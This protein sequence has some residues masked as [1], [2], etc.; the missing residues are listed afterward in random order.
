MKRII[1]ICS[2]V[3]AM[4]ILAV[5]CSK[6]LD[7]KPAASIDAETSLVEE[8]DFLT[9]TVGVYSYLRLTPLYGRQ[10]I[11]YPELLANNAAHHGQVTNLLALSR[12]ARGSHMTP[13]QRTYEAIAQINIILEQLE[14]NYIGSEEVKKQVRGQCLFLR[15]LYYHILA[16]VYGYEAEHVVSA[17]RNRGTVPLRTK[18][19][20]SW[21]KNENLPRATQEEFNAFLYAEL[22]EAYSLLT[23]SGYDRAPHFASPAAVAA[24]FSRVALYNKDWETTIHWST[25]ALQSGTGR[26]STRDTYVADWRTASHPESI[27]EVEFR[28]NENVGVNNAPRADFTNRVDLESTAPNGRG[29]ARVSD[30]LYALFADKD[31]RKELIWK[32]LGARSNDNQ[33]T[34]FIS[35]GGTP[36]LDNI[37]VIR[38]SEMYLNRAEAYAHMTGQEGPAIADL[39]TIRTR[40]GLQPASGLSEDALVNAILEQRRLEL[41]FEGH[42]FFDYKRRGQNIV[43]PD[44]T[45]L[46]F[47]DYRILGRIPWRDVNAAPLLTQNYN[48]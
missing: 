45:T 32:G 26:F 44:G 18:A 5:S 47:T 6:I 24:L 27:F 10:L 21:D 3:M 41:C 38:V 23:E 11:V 48:Y 39:N 29:I 15:A 2:V 20:Y 33:M 8:Q 40:A 4:S 35:R 28:I 31:V 17:S 1:Y 42:N 37:P 46:N 13:W 7:V 34:K 36:N 43:K 16:K 9:A 25:V 12:N 14:E 22:E 30:E 19:I